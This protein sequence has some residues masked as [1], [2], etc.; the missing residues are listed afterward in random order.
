MELTRK[1]KQHH[2]DSLCTVD[3]LDV[4]KFYSEHLERRIVHVFFSFL[5]FSFAHRL[6]NQQSTESQQNSLSHLYFVNRIINSVI[7]KEM[8][9]FMS[10]RNKKIHPLYKEVQKSY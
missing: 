10:N 5:S 2:A 9:C 6:D 8:T 4:I 3:K 7:Q 1:R